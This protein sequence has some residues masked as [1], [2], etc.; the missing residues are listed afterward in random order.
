MIRLFAVEG[1]KQFTRLFPGPEVSIGRAEGNDLKVNDPK[2]SRRHLKIERIPDGYKVVDLGSTVGTRVNGVA[3]SQKRLEPGD[4]IEIGNTTIFFQT[5]PET[6]DS[7]K[8]RALDLL[9]E[10][11][12]QAVDEFERSLGKDGLYEAERIFSDCLDRHGLSYLKEIEEGY[13]NLHK[14]LEVARVLT[15]ELETERLLRLI[16]D[17]AVELTG[18]ARGFVI[19]FNEHGQLEVPVARNFDQESIKKPAFKISR[20]IAEEVGV[21]GQAV[22][23]HNAQQDE[24]FSGSMSVTDLH[25]SSILCAPVRFRDRTLG[26]VYLDNPFQEGV[27]TEKHLAVLEAFAAQAAVA[28]ENS[29]RYGKARA[30]GPAPAPEAAE[31]A[32][33][34]AAKRRSRESLKY[35]YDAIIGESAALLQVLQ[36]LDKVIDSD[37]PILIQGESGTGKELVAKAIHENGPRHKAPFV[38]ENCAAIPATLLESELFG[39]RRGAFTGAERDKTGLFEHANGG[40][41]FLDEIGETSLEMQ[42]KLLRALQDGE[43]RPVGGKETIHV[44]VRIISA[45]NKNL[46]QLIQE[47][48]FREDLYYRLNVIAV[49]LPPLRARRE[50]I[51]LLVDHFLGKIARERGAEKRAIS[52]AAVFRLINREWR[53]NIRELESTIRKAVALSDG[54]ISDEVIDDGAI[55][56]GSEGRAGLSGRPLKE[57]V[58][59][60]TEKVERDAIL[61]AL[62]R[63]NWKKMKAAQLLGISR[64][65]LDAKIEAYGIRRDDGA[66]G[67]SAL[68]DNA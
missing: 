60:E 32:V 41:L 62:H 67:S 8:R 16:V 13:R 64:P 33:E 4:R 25:L 49:N 26:V 44:D 37:V 59:A 47:G 68:D 51:P 29:L 46:S 61:Q 63:T 53:G 34:P 1:Q 65:T 21:T 27:F 39:Y 40:T 48:K 10:R 19:L 35:R 22:L 15:S 23:A 66:G 54:T 7:K 45:S 24:R 43:I 3:V 11:L 6:A 42:K 20:S 9:E 14:L 12:R 31:A 56:L 52:E 28:I 18:A 57:I 2:V 36:L 58:R 55:G 17:A 5:G 30:S 50:D 38:S